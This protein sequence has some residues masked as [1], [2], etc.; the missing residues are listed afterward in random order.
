MEIHRGKRVETVD[1]SSLKFAMRK[2]RVEHVCLTD[3]SE[4]KWSVNFKKGIIS[5]LQASVTDWSKETNVTEETFSFEFWF[6]Y[7]VII[8]C[9][10]LVTIGI[11]LGNKSCSVFIPRNKIL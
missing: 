8:L 10:H 3:P 4:S 11:I 2:G 7:R 9:R 6:F 5:S 1:G